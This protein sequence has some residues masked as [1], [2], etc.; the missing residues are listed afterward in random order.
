VIPVRPNYMVDEGYIGGFDGVRLYYRTLGSKRTRPNAI[1]L[2]GGP[3]SNMNAIWPDLEPLANNHTI[4]MYDQRG[5]GR[6]ELVKD[7]TLLTAECHVRDLEAVRRHLGLENMTLIG[8]SWG[9]GLAA[10]Y[11]AEYPANV[12]RLL[13]LGPMPPT[14]AFSAQRFDEADKSTGFHDLLSELRRSMPT[15]PDPV[16]LCEQFFSVY[17]EPYFADPTAMARRRGSAC[18]APPE[19]VRNWLTVSDATFASL[20]DW[21]FLPLLSQL[22]VETLI[23]EGARSH[24]ILDGVRAWAA[25]IPNARLSLIP[26]AGH[27]PQVEQPELFF[28]AVD[29]FL[30]GNWQLSVTPSCKERHEVVKS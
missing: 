12:G 6:S 26:D 9:A 24:Q 30:S 28:P 5:G 15:A 20:G 17:L 11:T 10:L 21:D 18:D 19:A 4:L 3:G 2:H 29:I 8:H 23:I 13:L 1:L 25:A 16:A 14:K 22:Q 27:F 7:P